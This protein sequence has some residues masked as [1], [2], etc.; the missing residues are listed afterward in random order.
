MVGLSQKYLQLGRL[1]ATNAGL[2]R[3][4]TG[5]LKAM[6]GRDQMGKLGLKGKDC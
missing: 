4:Q 2:S 3:A 1:V 6:F 5:K